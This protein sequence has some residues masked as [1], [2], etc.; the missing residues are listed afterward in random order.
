MAISE[1]EPDEQRKP[2]AERAKGA[3]GDHVASIRPRQC[4]VAGDFVLISLAYHTGKQTAKLQ[5]VPSI[6]RRRRE[7][8]GY[9]QRKSAEPAAR[10]TTLATAR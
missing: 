4:A 10:K 5:P 2:T 7:A 3:F 1:R 8:G 9:S 6:D